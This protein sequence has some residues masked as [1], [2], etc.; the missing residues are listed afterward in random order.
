[1]I[2]RS[3]VSRTV[4]WGSRERWNDVEQQDLVPWRGKVQRQS[5]NSTLLPLANQINH[6]CLTACQLGQ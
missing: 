1:M 3:R 2:K 6:F 5:H 4:D